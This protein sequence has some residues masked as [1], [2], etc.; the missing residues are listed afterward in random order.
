[1]AFGLL[2]EVLVLFELVAPDALLG[3]QLET[4]RAM[5]QVALDSHRKH[6]VSLGPCVMEGHHGSTPVFGM[7]QHLLGL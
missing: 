2:D 7:A 3:G 6:V 4:H 1:M 5:E